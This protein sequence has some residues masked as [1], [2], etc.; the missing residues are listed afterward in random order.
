MRESP[1]MKENDD[2]GTKQID[3]QH[4][5]NPKPEQREN[6]IGSEIF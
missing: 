1:S 5:N 2:N 4:I 6:E 3:I